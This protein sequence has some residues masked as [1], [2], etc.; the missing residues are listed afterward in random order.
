MRHPIIP[1]SCGE[2]CGSQTKRLR[3]GGVLLAL[4]IL[5]ACPDPGRAVLLDDGPERV[6]YQGVQD[7]LWIRVL[8]RR[9]SYAIHAYRLEGKRRVLSRG[10][11][12]GLV[13]GSTTGLMLDPRAVAIVRRRF[14][15]S[16]PV[17]SIR[18]EGMHRYRIDDGDWILGFTS[19]VAFVPTSA[20][21]APERIASQFLA[22]A[23]VVDRIER[24]S[25]GI[26]PIRLVWR[27]GAIAPRPA[28]GLPILTPTQPAGAEGSL[29]VPGGDSL[30]RLEGD[31]MVDPSLPLGAEAPTPPP[32]P[33]LPR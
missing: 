13:E 4:A 2:T 20:N 9:T 3:L 8:R 33:R 28:I 15:P 30:E 7:G 23:E 11:W 21:P 1:P 25:R 19:K 26:D 24:L 27:P 29:A 22:R 10:S 6:L 12:L 5:V 17:R 18:I 32:I 14:S 16:R 31:V